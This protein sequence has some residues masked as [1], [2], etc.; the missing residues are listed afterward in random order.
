MR[1]FFHAKPAPQLMLM[2]VDTASLSTLRQTVAQICGDALEF[3]RIEACEH[4]ARMKVWV[5]VAASLVE[6]IM[7]AVMRRLPAAEFG[8][9]MAHEP[10]RSARVVA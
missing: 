7:E 8:R 9:C 3:M 5:C 10:Q 2:T 6:R 4:G 1:A